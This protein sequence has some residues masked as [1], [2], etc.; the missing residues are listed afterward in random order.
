MGSGIRSE[1][2]RV[3]RVACWLCGGIKIMRWWGYAWCLV[4]IAVG[5]YVMGMCGGVKFVRWGG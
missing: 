4:V 3:G 1:V 2:G 5:L